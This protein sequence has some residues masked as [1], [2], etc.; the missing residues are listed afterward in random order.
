[1]SEQTEMTTSG[2]DKD[3]SPFLFSYLLQPDGHGVKLDTGAIRD[4][5]PDDGDL[6]LHFDIASPGARQWLERDSGVPDYAAEALLAIETRPRT[7]VTAEGL[8]IVLRGVNTNP[9]EDPEDMVAVRVWV[10]PHRVISTR[11]RRLLSVIDIAKAL[12]EGNGP[13]DSGTLLAMLIDRLADRIGDFVDAIEDHLDRIEDGITTAPAGTIRTEL[14]QLRRQ[15][16]SVRRFLAPQRDALDRLYRQQIEFIDESDAHVMRE[17]SDRITRYLED[18]ELARE[19][20]VV[21]Q[22]ELLSNMAQEQNT[23]MYVLSVV[24]AIFLPLTFITGML[25]MNVGGLP[26]VNSDTGFL[27]SIVV[28]IVAAIVLLGYFRWKKWL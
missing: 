16:A 12:D 13:N 28:M 6:W 21:I 17:E 27:G 15:M 4:W 18:L 19:R 2:S 23:R 7:L 1:M 24:A 26:G 25:G 5:T 14:S 10:E 9:G 11:R 20:A 3:V 22:E 8:L